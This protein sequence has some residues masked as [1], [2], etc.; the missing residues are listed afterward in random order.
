MPV[1]SN[2]TSV[3]GATVGNRLIPTNF[4]LSSGPGAY[5][6]KVGSTVLTPY[7]NSDRVRVTSLGWRLTYTGPVATAAGL[8]TVSSASPTVDDKIVKTRGKVSC[9]NAFAVAGGYY[10]TSTTDQAMLVMP[11]TLV[12]GT[13][14]KDSIV[15]RPEATL[16]GIV[17]R[18]APVFSWKDFSNTP[19][20][21][22]NPVTG[23]ML[24]GALDLA[25]A[26]Q[27]NAAGSMI[28]GDSTTK[29]GS[30][31]V[32]DTDWDVTTIAVSG[33]N[34]DATY[35]LDT[36]MCVEYVPTT[37]S[38]F[39]SVAKTVTAGSAETAALLEKHAIS[40]PVASSANKSA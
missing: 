26:S 3:T 15:A 27:Y 40:S 12:A 5:A 16:Q 6:D 39:Y 17:R 25:T 28:S 30:I 22:V 35:R 1:G 20:F 2:I 29:M 14:T 33:I 7:I 34:A 18:N 11:Y 19:V 13:T 38:A 31:N 4:T 37:D 36:W 9:T 21:L 32:W 23:N 8:I 24:D 10:D